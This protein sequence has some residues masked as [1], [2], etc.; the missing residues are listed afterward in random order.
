MAEKERGFLV[1]LDKE[2]ILLA[3][4]NSKNPFTRA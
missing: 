2:P 3:V 4:I 1:L